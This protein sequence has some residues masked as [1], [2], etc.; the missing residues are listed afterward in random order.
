LVVQ[1]FGQDRDGLFGQGGG[2]VMPEHGA[3]AGGEFQFSGEGGVGSAPSA[4]GVAVDSGGSSGFRG[5]HAFSEQAEDVVLRGREIG[6]W[7]V[8]LGFL[9]GTG[10]YRGIPGSRISAEVWAVLRDLG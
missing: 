8:A 2:L 1:D 5:G 6:V 7:R 10:S 4:D 3:L 9:H